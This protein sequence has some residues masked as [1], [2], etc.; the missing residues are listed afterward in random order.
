MP[1]RGKTRVDK[2]A[3]LAGGSILQTVIFSNCR[4]GPS[5]E[6]PDQP[7]AENHRLGKQYRFSLC[8]DLPSGNNFV[9]V[10]FCAYNSLIRLFSTLR[11]LKHKERTPI[12]L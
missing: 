7:S 3:S 2:T 11:L 8:M 9:T 12:L 1:P 4:L 6:E 5:P 10:F